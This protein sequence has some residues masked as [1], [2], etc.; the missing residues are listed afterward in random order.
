MGTMDVRHPD[1]MEFIQAKREDGRLRQFNLSLLITEDFIQAV[2]DDQEWRLIFPFNKK[3][4]EL[5]G[6]DLSAADVVWADWPSN[7][8]TSYNVCYTKLLRKEW[9][10]IFPFNKKEVEQ[11][12]TELSGDDVVWADWPTKEGVVINAQGLVAC[13]VYKTMP[14]RRLCVITS[15]SIHYT[16]LYERCVCG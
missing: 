6:T 8:I 11:D 13:K 4:V 1:V 5:D 15:Y 7:R 9:K 10:L 16:K 14:A 2:R 3:E 12:N